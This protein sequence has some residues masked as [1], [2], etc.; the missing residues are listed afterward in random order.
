MAGYYGF[1]LVV[2]VSV[3]M[4]PDDNLVNISGFSPNLVCALIFWRS[5]LGLLMGK[6]CQ[7]LTELS[8][9]DT[10]IFSFPDDNLSK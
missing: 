2:R 9:R 8:A 1:T 10:P 6:C 7:F 3:R 5:G 4:F